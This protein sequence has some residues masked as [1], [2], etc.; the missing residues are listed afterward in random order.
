[1]SAT[2][3]N[4]I[5]VLLLL[6]I[7]GN[8]FRKTKKHL[9]GQGDCC[10]GGDSLEKPEAKK[11]EAAIIGR[12]Q[13]FI[14]GMTCEKCENKLTRALNDLDG[15]AVRSVNHSRGTAVVDL[16]EMVPDQL[17]TEVV[18]RLGYQVKDIIFISNK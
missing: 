12:K 3:T 2:M 11:L 13:L 16:T 1:M 15:V 17:L 5:I 8:G 10:G 9:Q 14:E 4:V 6:L 18:E 7:V